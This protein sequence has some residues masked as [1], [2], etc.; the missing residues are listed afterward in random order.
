M[1]IKPI[2]QDK[3]LVQQTSVISRSRSCDN[4]SYDHSKTIQVG[5]DSQTGSDIK[6]QD[7]NNQ[8]TDRDLITPA[9]PSVPAPLHIRDSRPCSI[10]SNI[11]VVH[12]SKEAYATAPISPPQASTLE[13][14]QPSWLKRQ[15]IRVRKATK[16]EPKTKE[17]PELVLPTAPTDQEKLAYLTTNRVLLYAFGVFGFLSLCTGMWLFVISSWMFAWFGLFVAA[18]Q[19]YMAISYFVG[20]VGRDWDY[21]GHQKIL[22]ETPLTVNNIPTVDIYLPV[23]K[24]PLEI[25]RNTWE[26]VSKLEWPADKI[27]VYVLDD[28]AMDSVKAMAAEF[29]FNYIV[30]DDRPRLKKAGNLRW[31]FTRTYGEF[32]NIYDADFCPRSDFLKETIPR[33]L[34]DPEIAVLQTPQFF[35]TS[36]KQT[37]VEQGAGGVQE[38]FYR[39]VQVNRD[40]WGAS[41]C[42]GSNAVY[43]RAALEEVGGTAEIGFSEDVHTGFYAVN[44][45]WKLRY[46]PL[47]LACGVC[48]DSP[49]AFFSQQ[50]R[51]CMGSTTLLSNP[52]FWKSNLSLIQKI[53]YLCGF[54]YYSA[55]ALNI[56]VSPLPGVLLIWT[57]PEFFKYYNIFFAVPSLITTM[58]MMRCW[59]KARYGLNVQHIMII[60]NYAYLTTI[61]D[62]ILGRGLA[63][64][65]SGDAKAHKNNKYRNMRILAWTWLLTW[66]GALIAGMIYQIVRGLEWYQC[67]PL[68]LLDILNF[69]LAYR[70]LLFS[71]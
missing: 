8:P 28:G 25:L 49:R 22:E 38:L 29:G 64:A 66:F 35:R 52:D 54:M 12:A 27:K 65:P 19:I 3:A 51:W 30:R 62:K 61:K 31:A 20:L 47:C 21:A 18:L 71:N 7:N 40:R 14:T 11:D 5:Q 24:E 33:M 1:S 39:V 58:V 17:E 36:E 46:I 70:F 48:P 15:M 53:C 50:M 42:V 10:S 6:Q 4:I 56:F 68:L 67:I 32:F 13:S 57:R 55:C 45:G 9:R 44:R 59:A 16:T 41:I 34:H 60:Q 63:W 43:R 69:Y 2:S 37:W 26:H 23:A